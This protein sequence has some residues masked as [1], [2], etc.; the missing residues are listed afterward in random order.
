MKRKSSE[1]I[2]RL[3]T[4]AMLSALGFVLM[5]FCRFSYPF[6]PWLM[7]EISDIVVL[8]AYVLYGFPGS[9]LTAILKTALDMSINGLSGFAGIGNITALITSFTYILAL[10]LFSHVF[11]LFN[12]GIWHRIIGYILITLFVSIVLTTL[13]CLFIT[14]TYLCGYFTS[15]FDSATVKNIVSSLEQMGYSNMGYVGAIIVIYL[16]FNLMKGAIIFFVYELV[17]N[18]IIFVLMKRSPM[19]KKYFIGSVFDK[20]ASKSEQDTKKCDDNK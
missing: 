9:I 7:I 19:M 13:N 3:A 12:K 15:C 6:A 11:R 20:K 18:R 2:S 16:P 5:A 10:Y 4:I 1:I 17:F 14:P 8:L